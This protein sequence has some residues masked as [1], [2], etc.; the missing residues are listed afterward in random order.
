[1]NSKLLKSVNAICLI[2][3]LLIIQACNQSKYSDQKGD[4]FGLTPPGKNAEVFGPNIISMPGRGEYMILFSQDGNECYISCYQQGR[5]CIYYSERVNNKWLN[6]SEIAFAKNIKFEL[7]NISSDSNTIYLENS[8][9]IWMSDRKDGLWSEPKRLPSPINS[10]SNDHGYSISSDGTIV[11]S[12]SR[13]NETG[14]SFDIWSIKAGSDKAENL[15]S[16]VNTQIRNI[17]PC[18][19]KDGSYIIFSTSDTSYEYLYISFY[20]GHNEWTKPVDMNIADTK[21]NVSSYQN[22]PTISPDG[23]YLFFNSH[24]SDNANISDIYWVSTDI[25]EDIKKKVVK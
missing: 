19:A 5:S 1:M 9:D 12:S 25:I 10:N 3:L 13:E 18:I 17:T 16:V 24:N 15:G 11:I 4:Y 20:L 6:L 21:I 22:R 23:K 8:N 7:S 2:C 14:N